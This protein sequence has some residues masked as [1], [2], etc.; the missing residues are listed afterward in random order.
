MPSVE[1]PLPSWLTVLPASGDPAPAALDGRACR[2]R[3]DLFT[4]AAR[5]LRL[6]D[7]F[8]RNW[9]AFYDC[10]R[11]LDDPVLTVEHAEELLADE[12][13]AQLTLLLDLLSDARLRVAL[14]TSHPRELRERLLSAL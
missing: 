3:A 4:E 12:P 13:S 1:R 6:P 9:D 8:G 11:D 5:A 2:T 7:H 14:A 10:L